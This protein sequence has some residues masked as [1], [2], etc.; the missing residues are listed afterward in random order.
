[1]MVPCEAGV[2]GGG[3]SPAAAGVEEGPG[4]GRRVG[5]EVSPK[6]DDLELEVLRGLD[7]VADEDG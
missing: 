5:D 3:V 7:D 6:G 1:M 2:Y 4:D